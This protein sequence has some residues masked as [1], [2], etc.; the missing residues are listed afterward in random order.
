MYGRDAAC[1]SQ[2]DST[3]STRDAWGGSLEELACKCS[4]HPPQASRVEGV[5]A[6][7]ARQQ[8]FGGWG[9]G[10]GVV[11]SSEFCQGLKVCS[12]HF[13]LA[14]ELLRSCPKAV[15]GTP[16]F[17]NIRGLSLVSKQTSLVMRLCRSSISL[18]CH[19]KQLSCSNLCAPSHLEQVDVVCSG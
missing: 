8:G 12:G 5:I 6:A 15:L 10:G 17:A 18:C 13:R 14:L 3:P 16:T 19:F 9:G 2:R 1:N 4:R 7:G 11:E